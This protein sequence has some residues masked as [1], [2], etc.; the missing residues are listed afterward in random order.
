[1]TFKNYSISECCS[2]V[3]KA[4]LL[5]I[6]KK[7]YGIQNSEADF[8]NYFSHNWAKYNIKQ[9]ETIQDYKRISEFMDSY[10]NQSTLEDIYNSYCS[11]YKTDDVFF[12]V[13]IK[14][15]RIS[16]IFGKDA[17]FKN[18]SMYLF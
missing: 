4:S 9:Y 7:V 18:N 8:L 6:L 12:Q 17:I 5:K 2:L 15:F 1:M 11:K 3:W 16:L 10:N 14:D 13:D